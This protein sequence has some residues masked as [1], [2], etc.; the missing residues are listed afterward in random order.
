MRNN[1]V[2]ANFMHGMAAQMFER[3]NLLT[4]KAYAGHVNFADLTV[5]Y[6]RDTLTMP[7]GS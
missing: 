1:P 3:S 5:R 7:A 6:L 2:I 4:E